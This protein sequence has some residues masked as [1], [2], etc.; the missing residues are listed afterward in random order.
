MS[1]GYHRLS[2]ELGITDDRLP[3]MRRLWDEGLCDLDWAHMDDD[4]K[5]DVCGQCPVKSLCAQLGKGEKGEVWG[6][7]LKGTKPGPTCKYGHPMT[8]DN[9]G[10]AKSGKHYCKAC[11]RILSRARYRS[12]H[13]IPLDT[14]LLTRDPARCPHGHPRTEK[15]TRVDERGGRHC[16]VCQ[17]LAARRAYAAKAQRAA[18]AGITV[19]EQ[20]RRDRESKGLAA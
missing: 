9:V 10:I 8:G 12:T 14:P 13:G 18:E 11:N 4:A 1:A 6:G 5:R 7:E 15:N 17:R 19:T 2:A 3:D 20:K 16:R